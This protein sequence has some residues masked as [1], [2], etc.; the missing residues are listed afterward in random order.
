MGLQEVTVTKLMLMLIL[1]PL[2]I[3]LPVPEESMESMSNVRNARIKLKSIRVLLPCFS[4][5]IWQL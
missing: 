3:V 5:P 2:V 4:I 1:M